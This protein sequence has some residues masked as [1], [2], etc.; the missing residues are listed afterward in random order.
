MPTVV[1]T[2]PLRTKQQFGVG[3][4]LPAG[5]QVRLTGE[6]VILPPGMRCVV[7]LV[8]DQRYF[9]YPS[10]LQWATAYPG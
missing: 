7:I 8:D 9:V 10:E 2:Y 3:P 6:H 5:T 1:L 4:V